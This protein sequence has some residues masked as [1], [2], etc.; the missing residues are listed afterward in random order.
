MRTY[1]I[2]GFKAYIRNHIELGD[3]FASLVASRTDIFKIVTT[4]AFALT[5]LQIVPPTS[6]NGTLAC[7]NILTKAVYD[8]MY[9]GGEILLTSTIIG[10]VY[11][12][13]VVCANPKTEEKYMRRAFEILVDATEEVFKDERRD[14]P[15]AKL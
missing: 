15:M 4:P 1:G 10:G 7:A 5:A 14:L 2:N 13:R 9:R 11:I 12:I 6:D 3:L 8:N